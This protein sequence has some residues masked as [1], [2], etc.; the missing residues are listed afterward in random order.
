MAIILGAIP[1]TT[2]VAFRSSASMRI[3]PESAASS[4][5]PH[6]KD[7]SPISLMDHAQFWAI[8]ERTTSHEADTDDQTS[9]LRSEL[10]KLTADEIASFEATFD[11]IMRGSYSWN[12]W[13]AAYVVHGG[14]S[15]DGFEY[16]RVWLISKGQKIFEAVSKDPDILADVL[17]ADSSGPL[18]YEDFA[19]V[20]REAWEA[21]SGKDLDEMPRVADMIYPGV[22]P[23]GDPFKETD[24]Y[25]AKRYPKLWK[26]F[27]HNPAQ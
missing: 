3:A 21:K 25:L 26:R 9:A 14:A 24:E 4:E 18:E 13:G 12:L 17:A 1:L 20:A 23:S 27:G 5:K 6:P 19:Y 8:I 15:D 10:S 22:E 11:E 2:L 7:S 16:F